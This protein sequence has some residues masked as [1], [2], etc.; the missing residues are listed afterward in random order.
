MTRNIFIIN[1]N[2]S[3]LLSVFRALEYLDANPKLVKSPED[4]SDSS[5]IILPGVGAFGPA[6]QL[7][8]KTG[9]IQYL[10]Q[11]KNNP[12]LGICLGMQLLFSSSSEFG[13]HTGLDIIKGDIKRMENNR[14]NIR[15]PHVG[16]K[17]VEPVKNVKCSLTQNISSTSKFYFIHSYGLLDSNQYAVATTTYEYIQFASIVEK[18]NIF[19]CQFHPE[20]SSSAGLQLLRNFIQV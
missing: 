5:P 6:I 4:I 15:L 9:F 1:Y 2:S 10:K 8:E 12:I 16:W 20:K 14:N 11:N 13:N 19:G 18:A 7:L 17:S 3:N